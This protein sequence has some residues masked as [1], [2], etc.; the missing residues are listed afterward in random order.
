MRRRRQRERRKKE[1]LTRT[2][3]SR[4]LG[5]SS[6]EEDEQV[7]CGQGK[8]EVALRSCKDTKRTETQ[9][10]QRLK[11]TRQASLQKGQKGSKGKH[12]MINTNSFTTAWRQSKAVCSILR[13][14]KNIKARCKTR[15]TNIA[16]KAFPKTSSKNLEVAGTIS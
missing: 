13:G 4:N 1:S 11:G 9:L 6:I 2:R 10:A 8:S 7:R 5:M 12:K 14:D 16:L 15:S 3:M